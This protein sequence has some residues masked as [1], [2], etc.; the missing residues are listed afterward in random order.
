M[1]E[2]HLSIKGTQYIVFFLQ[3]ITICSNCAHF[4]HNELRV[5]LVPLA[6]CRCK[7]RKKNSGLVGPIN[8]IRLI[9]KYIAIFGLKLTTKLAETFSNQLRFILYTW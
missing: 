1:L 7:F 9:D 2:F 6:S 4:I 8:R 3:I 5:S